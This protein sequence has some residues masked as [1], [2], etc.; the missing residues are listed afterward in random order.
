MSVLLRV[1]HLSK[2]FGTHI[3]F[4]DAELTISEGQKIGLVGRNGAGKSTFLRALTGEER[5]DSGEI[6]KTPQ[7]RLGYL[8]QLAAFEPNEQVL[9]YLERLSGKPSWECSRMAA[10][11]DIKRDRLDT[12]I[13]SLSGGW[14]MRVRLSALLLQDPNL[15][16]LD[17][18]T[19][20]LDLNT[21]LL[22]EEFLRN[23]Q[24]GFITVSHDREFLANTCTHTLELEHG[25]FMLY[26]GAIEEYLAWKEEKMALDVKFN[27]NIDKER[28]HLMAFVER[29]GA[30]ASKA[31]QAQSK[32]KQIRRLK[33]IEIKHKLKTVRILIPPLAP[34]KTFAVRALRLSIGYSQPVATDISFEIERGEKVAILGENGVG[35]STLLKTLAGE[36]ERKDGTY[37]WNNRTSCAFYDQHTAAK[38]DEREKV[39]DYLLRMT[40][41]EVEPELMLRMA[42][43]FLFTKDDFDKRIAMLSGG[44]R[45]RLALAG[46]LLRKP[47]ALLLDEPTNH[48]DL[49]TVEALGQ[50]LEAWNG[51]VIFVSHSRTFVHLLATKIIELR[52]GSAKSFGGTYDE[53]VYALQSDL[54]PD[55]SL[56]EEKERT[57]KQSSAKA[58]HYEKIKELK[59]AIIKVE[60]ELEKLENER[61]GIM[62][63]F[64]QDPKAFNLERNRRITTLATMIEHAENEWNRLTNELTEA[65][66]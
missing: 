53:Y 51:T 48:L 38:L 23:F 66:A 25:K 44:E 55:P 65:E 45:S 52:G 59:R 22:L 54:T 26:P 43:N 30:K 49:E 3:L 16:L 37:T 6:I 58:E 56:L 14:Q 15:L 46:I 40:S 5:A 10:T 9:P 17:E 47:D 63:L 13:S 61:S 20:Y 60:K 11:F 41:S 62:K 35:K 64:T 36:L 42:G 50:A 32:L 19:N 33:P 18:P 8:D 24:G 34:R 21:Q 31:S 7:L 4:D 1:E 57:E 28:K 2:A 29:F 39:G 27:Q 12:K